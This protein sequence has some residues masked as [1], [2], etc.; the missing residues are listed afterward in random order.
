[1]KQKL[2]FAFEE[3]Q[4]GF[5]FV[6]SMDFM[7]KSI[8]LVYIEICIYSILKQ[9]KKIPKAS[10]QYW[11]WR[12]KFCCVK[13]WFCSKAAPTGGWSHISLQSDRQPLCHCGWQ[14]QEQ[15]QE[16]S[17]WR[18]WEGKLFLSGNH[19]GD[20]L[21]DCCCKYLNQNGCLGGRHK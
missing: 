11:W 4:L 21:N 16:H 19:R 9:T 5:F 7:N 8:C 13:K 15:S 2:I 17:P 10:H 20:T 1:M 6:F 14:E 3:I 18:C 12:N